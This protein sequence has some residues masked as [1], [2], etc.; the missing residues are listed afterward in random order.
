[1]ADGWLIKGG[2]QL[3]FEQRHTLKLSQVIEPFTVD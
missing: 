2:F 1:M 3:G